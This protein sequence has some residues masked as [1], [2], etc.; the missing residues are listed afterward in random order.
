MVTKKYADNLLAKAAETR[1]RIKAMIVDILVQLGARDEDTAVE[2][3]AENELA[4]SF[5]SVNCAEEADGT[6]VYIAL[7]WIDKRGLRV[8]YYNPKAWHEGDKFEYDI[9]LD[10][11]SHV[12]YEEILKWLKEK[13]D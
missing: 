9:A 5:L 2:F 11:E 3:D 7:L 6:E 10:S 1:N 12:D 8:N 4:P 13:I